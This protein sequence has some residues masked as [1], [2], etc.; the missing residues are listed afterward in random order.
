[1][2]PS[3][4]D[5]RGSEVSSPAQLIGAG[6]IDRSIYRLAIIVTVPGPNPVV[7]PVPYVSVAYDVVA[8]ESAGVGG[9]PAITITAKTPAG[10]TLNDPLGGR[11][12][13]VMVLMQ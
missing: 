2:A 9:L 5:A 11:S 7:F 10:F 13:D 12:F 6:P 4:I 8:I 1:M 3:Q